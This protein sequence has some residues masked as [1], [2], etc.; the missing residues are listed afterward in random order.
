MSTALRIAHGEFGRVAL[1]DMDR[2]AGA[3]RAP[4]LPC[5]DQGERCR[6]AIRRRRS[7][8]AAHRYSRRCSI[9][10]WEPHAYVHYQER[11][12][13][14]ILALYIEP[15][16]AEELPAEL[17]RERRTWLLRTAR[18]RRCR[19]VSAALSMDLATQMLADPQP[20]HGNPAVGL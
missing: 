2:F 7:S 18:R 13:T 16:L 19:R 10:T 15:D 6:H 3:P 11:P 4:A 8:G 20:S 17:G 1:L 14:T 12:R 5:A 9:N